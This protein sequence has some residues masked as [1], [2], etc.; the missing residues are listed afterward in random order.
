VNPQKDWRILFIAVFLFLLIPVALVEYLPM[1]DL[2][3]HLARVHILNN[4][5]RVAKFQEVYQPS[6]ELLPNLALDLFLLPLVKIMP[7]ETAARVFV[8]TGMMIFALG[9]WTISIAV[10]GRIT[11]FAALALFTQY[12]S[13]FFY[14]FIAFQMGVAVSLVALGLWYMWR[15]HWTVVRVSLLIALAFLA[16]L[17]HLGGYMYL[18][19]AIGWLTLL[20]W[21]RE[22][23]IEPASLIGF[24]PLVPPLLILFAWSKGPGGTALFVFSTLSQKLQHA[25][26]LLISFSLYVDIAVALLLAVAILSAWALGKYR[27]QFE[28]ASLAAVFAVAFVVFPWWLLTGSDADTRMMLGAGVFLLLALNCEIGQTAGKLIYSL[29]LTAL[30]LRIAFCGWVWM[31]QSDFIAGHVA[32]LNAIPEGARVYPI[33]LFPEQREANKFERVLLHVPDLAAVSRQAIV[34]TVFTVKRQHSLIEKTPIWY[35]TSFDHAHPETFDWNRVA[36]EYDVIWQYG[37]DPPLRDFFNSRF[38]LIG[39]HGEARLYLTRP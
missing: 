4:Y 31:R 18:G 35:S 9:C 34:P 7:V 22:K 28:L 19:F 8:A 3:G 20:Q 21:I 24:I 39:Q 36:R 1:V 15:K 25:T 32:F 10:H 38:Y 14:G 27:F 30:M 37:K 17:C 6:R 11:P 5:E 13:M 29:A 23:R 33:A 12:N 26:V 2:P 16:C